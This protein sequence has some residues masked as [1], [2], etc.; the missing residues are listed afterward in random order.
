MDAVIGRERTH[1]PVGP[2]HQPLRTEGVEHDLQ[3]GTEVLAVPTRS[4]CASVTMPESL[5]NTLGRSASRF[6]S[7]FQGDEQPLADRR[8]GDVVEHEELVLELV[9]QRDGHRQ[10]ARKQQQIVGELELGEPRDAAAELGPEHEAVVRLV[11]NDVTHAHELRMRREALELRGQLRGAQ[12]DPA[13]DA[14]D[15]GVPL[16]EREQP[17][18]LLDH[19]PGLHRDRAVEPGG[20]QQGSEL[21]GQVVAS[22]RGHGVGHPDVVGRVVAPEVLVGVDAHRQRVARIEDASSG[23]HLES[24]SISGTTAGGRDSSS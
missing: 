17:L 5:Q 7:S 11:V 24:W 20:L 9:D 19:L 8:L 14:L 23:P 18:G 13:D 6:R 4:S 21:V 16:G 1:R 22:Q 15:R 12:V 3:I 2:D 10:V